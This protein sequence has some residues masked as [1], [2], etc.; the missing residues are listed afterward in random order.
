MHYLHDWTATNKRY[1]RRIACCVI[2]VFHCS[3]CSHCSHSSHSYELNEITFFFLPEH[4][5]FHVSRL[6][7]LLLFGRLIYHKRAQAKTVQSYLSMWN[8]SMKMIMLK[9]LMFEVACCS[10][11]FLLFFSSS[12]RC[13]SLSLSLKL[14]QST[15]PSNHIRKLLPIFNFI[16]FR[17]D[18]NSMLGSY[19]CVTIVKRG[20]N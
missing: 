1:D 5:T 11:L 3:H 4:D 6:I 12:C 9:N 13:R 16:S 17:F 19:L 15:I 8:P 2:A 14:A 7:F 18:E 20:M 10:V